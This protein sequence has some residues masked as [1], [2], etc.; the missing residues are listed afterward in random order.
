MAETEKKN[1]AKQMQTKTKRNQCKTM[2]KGKKN[3]S[4]FM[5][6]DTRSEMALLSGFIF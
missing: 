2:Q 5:R 6:V 3:E 1:C 4:Y